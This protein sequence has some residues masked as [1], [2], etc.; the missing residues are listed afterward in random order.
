M[1]EKFLFNDNEKPNTGKEYHG[2][3]ENFKNFSGAEQET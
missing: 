3:K 1:P 2:P